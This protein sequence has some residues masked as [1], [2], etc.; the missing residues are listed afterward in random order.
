MA[1]D[2]FKNYY[3]FAYQ[4]K[5]GQGIHF[6]GFMYPYGDL[7]IYADAQIFFVW[8]LQLLR[9]LGMD[10]EPYLLGIVNSLPLISFVIAGLF[11]IRIF[12]N[13]K[14]PY[15]FA[16]L[17]SVICIGLSPQIFRIQSHYALAYAY[18]IPAVWWFNIRIEKSEKRAWLWVVM[19]CIF[20]F[21]HGFVHPY[22][23]FVVSIFVLSLWVA[24]VLLN[25]K[26][27]LGVLI[28]GI[29][30]VLGFLLIMKGVDV[31]S[32]RPK[33]PYGLLLFKSEASDL[34]PFF[35]WFNDTFIDLLSLRKNYNEGYAYVGM[36]IL[37]VP[38]LLLIKRA[39]K[40]KDIVQDRIVVGKS[41]WSYF[42]AGLLCLT[43]GMGLHIILTGGLI[44]DVLPMIKQFRVMGR[45]SWVFYY[46][47]FVFLAIIF[48]QLF[49]SIESKGF[50][51]LLMMLVIA[52]WG[53]D[54][55]N[56]HNTLNSMVS[57]YKS[58]NILLTSTQIKDILDDNLIVPSKYQALWVLPSSSEGTEKISFQDDWSSKMNAIPYSYQTGLPLTSIVMS[59]S[60]IAN[61]LKVMQ[62]SS[63]GYIEKELLKDINSDKDF[64]II[65]PNDRKDIFLDILDR[66]TLIGE[67]KDF[68]L[69]EISVST[70]KKVSSVSIAL[71]E[72]ADTSII[73]GGIFLDFEENAPGGLLSTACK[74]I[75]GE[76]QLFE[77]ELDIQDSVDYSLSLWY[78]ILDD[79]SNV[80]HFRL[81][82]LD[83]NRQVKEEYYFRDWDMK[84]VEV[85][86]NWI[87]LKKSYKF[88]STDKFIRVKAFGQFLHLDRLLF[89]PDEFNF[90]SVTSDSNFVQYN[91]TIGQ[92][93]L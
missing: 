40:R 91:H 83:E 7:A 18:L 56:Y 15:H 89:K 70:L 39:F 81:E 87:R 47:I 45:V 49:D 43:C 60:S 9:T 4:Y 79:R 42:I 82:T 86:G 75:N 59:R 38:V 17:F 41:L 72:Q 54:I 28:Q 13:Y 22:L 93:E 12:E 23:I 76:E 31:I 33:N 73:D 74:V 3:T 20:I 1:G 27:S 77:I 58:D 10:A 48:Y 63:S 92:I 35:G 65:I 8:I 66:A 5:Y 19:S 50:K 71:Y 85:I 37:I 78:Q 30:P 68:S 55:Y 2:G 25:R 57:K 69:F 62:L 11:L 36:L 84:R 46:T 6:D 52:L 32:D 34:L 21:V 24:K 14:V 88:S 44:L 51:W 53:L 64:L 16:I 26:L 90:R 61:S 67:R 80:P 29:I